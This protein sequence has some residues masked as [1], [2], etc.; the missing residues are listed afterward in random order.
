MIHRWQTLC[1]TLTPRKGNSSSSHGAQAA[2]WNLTPQLSLAILCP[3]GLSLILEPAV[4]SGASPLSWMAKVNSILYS[5]VFSN[6]S[7]GGEA[8]FI[9]LLAAAHLGFRFLPSV[10]LL[11]CF[12]VKLAMLLLVKMDQ[13][14]S[15][16]D[17][18]S[19][20]LFSK[21]HQDVE[22]ISLSSVLSLLLS[23]LSSRLFDKQ[24]WFVLNWQRC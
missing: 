7:G 3:H 17:T 18:P 24:Y 19:H 10:I 2:Y 5:H 22:H 9:F 8:H 23:I 16:A 15:Q 1:T 12:Y 20:S 4:A 13:S 11:C 21:K 14:W 6:T